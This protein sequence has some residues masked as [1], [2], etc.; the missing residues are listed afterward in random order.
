LNEQDKRPLADFTPTIILKTKDFADDHFAGVGKMVNIGFCY[1]RDFALDHAPY[2][3]PGIWG[4]VILPVI[5]HFEE[6]LCSI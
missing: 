5:S 6:T 1:Q 2:S 4:S 3:F